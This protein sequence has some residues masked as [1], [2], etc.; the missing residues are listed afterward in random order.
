[1]KDTKIDWIKNRLRETNYSKKEVADMF[2]LFQKE[3]NADNWREESYSRLIRKCYNELIADEEIDQETL[4]DNL[5]SLESNKQKIT[6]K[7]N[8]LRKVN[9]ENYRQYN[10]VEETYDNYVKILSEIDLTKFKIVEHKV[11][12]EDSKIGI[13]QLT[14]THFNTLLNESESLGNTYNFDV[15][16]KRLKKFITETIKEFKLQ[17]VTDCYLFM[18]GDLVSSSRRLQ[19]VLSMNSSICMASIIATKF[20]MQ[21]IIAI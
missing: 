19:E 15:A 14:D 17:N 21:A 4:E 11:K 16:S 1:M 13:C 8:Y 20:L 7:N 10:V 3:M 12:K 18:T 6:D 2:P 9:R 5:I